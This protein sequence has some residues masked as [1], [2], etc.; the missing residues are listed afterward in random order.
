[1]NTIEIK[2]LIDI[3]NTRAVRPNQGTPEQ[4]NQYRN[5]TTLCQCAEIRSIMSY[6]QDPQVEKVDVKKLGFGSIYKGK[7]LVWTFRFTPDRADVYL[8]NSGN[9]VGSLEAD[10]DQIPIIKN[11]TETINIDKAIFDL[12]DDQ[13]KNTIITAHPGTAQATQDS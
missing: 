13:Y 5:F 3:T 11:L 4:L 8:N 2:T 1:M 10:L 9:P 12:K 7:H 6:D